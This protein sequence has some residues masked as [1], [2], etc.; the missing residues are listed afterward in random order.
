MNR[1]FL[2]C[3][4]SSEETTKQVQ[5]IESQKIVMMQIAQSNELVIA[6]TITDEKSATKPHQRA[7]FS[8]LL[9]RV[10]KKEAQVILTWKIDRLSRNPL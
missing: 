9:D 3:R 4:K 2:Y 10:Q 8:S 1:C 6:D 5:S 7:G